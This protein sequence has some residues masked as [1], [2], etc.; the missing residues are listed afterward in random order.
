[1]KNIVSP[2]ARRR[3]PLLQSWGL[4]LGVALFCGVVSQLARPNALPWTADRLQRHARLARA[5]DILPI[6]AE[7]ALRQIERGEVIVLDARPE[8]EYQLSHIPGAVSF[9]NRNRETVYAEFAAVLPQGQPLLVY[10]SSMECTDALELG[11]FLIS[12]GHNDVRLL[13]GGMESWKKETRE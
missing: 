7:Q 1:M 11:R 5:S 13:L 8:S 4:L 9:S 12:Q 6:D 3:R 2:F 10:C